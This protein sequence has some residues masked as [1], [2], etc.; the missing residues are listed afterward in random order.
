MGSEFFLWNP[1]QKQSGRWVMGLG[2]GRAP[3]FYE[4]AKLIEA[5]IGLPCGIIDQS[6]MSEYLVEGEVFIR[7]FEEFMKWEWQ[8]DNVEYLWGWAEIAAGMIM[9]ITLE[10]RFWKSRRGPALLPSRYTIGE[11]EDSELT[12]KRNSFMPV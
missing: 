6:Q 3:L 9:N 2:V 8:G 10:P 1:I 11:P 5:K 12:Q 7:F 4:I